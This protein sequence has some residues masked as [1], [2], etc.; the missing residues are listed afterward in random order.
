VLDAEDSDEENPLQK[1]KSIKSSLRQRKLE[2][3]QQFMTAEQQ[4]A[5]QSTH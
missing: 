4:L 1:M 3:D 5:H 2:A